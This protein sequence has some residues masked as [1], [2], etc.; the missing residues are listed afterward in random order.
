LYGTG[1]TS[2]FIVG[3][4]DY[5]RPWIAKEN[6]GADEGEDAPGYT[7]ITQI[8]VEEGI[9][10]IGSAAFAYI[11]NPS[12]EVSLPS[13]LK[14]IGDVAFISCGM[15][16]ISIP[17][18]VTTI[19]YGAFSGCS[20]IRE[21]RLPDSLSSLGNG[22]FSGA[23]HLMTVTNWNKSLTEIPDSMFAG[24]DLLNF[25]IPNGVTRI[26]MSAFS[27]TL[28]RD[29][30]IP[31]SVTTIDSHAFYECYNLRSVTFGKN[32]K[33]EIG[34][35]SFDGCLRLKTVV[36][37]DKITSVGNAAFRGCS[38][39][40]EVTFSKKLKTIKANAFEGC[41]LT[42]VTLPETL[43]SIGAEAFKDNIAM[44]AVQLGSN[45]TTIK[46]SAFSGCKRLSVVRVPKNQYKR[47]KELLKTPLAKLT[48]VKIEKLK[49]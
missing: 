1:K 37:S 39:L 42:G 36:M 45:V 28:M 21:V 20:N 11:S 13:T 24:T 30:V 31:D 15:A 35:C 14:Q 29:V 9:T 26:G 8:V 33:G 10:S 25:E 43:K 44:V 48:N 7:N 41:A 46:K 34:S 19:G 16:E 38:S 47:Y 32:V 23:E 49:K 27:Q 3:H 12:L 5:Q 40:K 17:D 22:V 2:N 6:G 18:S 4:N